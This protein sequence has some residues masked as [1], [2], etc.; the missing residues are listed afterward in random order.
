VSKIYD[1]IYLG[2]HEAYEKAW[3]ALQAEFPE[4]KLENGSDFIHRHRFSISLNTVGLNAYH[5][6][7]L[8]LGLALRSMSFQTLMTMEPKKARSLVD[9]WKERKDD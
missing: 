5:L 8:D 7:I 3:N 6:R 2:S 1:L 9:E 4:A